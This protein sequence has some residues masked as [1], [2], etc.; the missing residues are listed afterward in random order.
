MQP[1]RARTCAASA[2]NDVL[3]A[4]G[5]HPGDG[6]VGCLRQFEKLGCACG[7]DSSWLANAAPSRGT[8]PGVPARGSQHLA[9]GTCLLSERRS[10]LATS[11]EFIRRSGRE[12]STEQS[13]LVLVALAM[14]S[15]GELAVTV[16]CNLFR[17]KTHVN[18]ISRLLEP[19][20]NAIEHGRAERVDTT[21]ERLEGKL[22]FAVTEHNG[23]GMT[24]LD[25]EEAIRF[26]H[27]AAKA[28]AKVLHNYAH[29]G[30]GTK[31]CLNFFSKLA[32]FSVVQDERAGGG[33]TYVLL[34]LD[35]ADKNGDGQCQPAKRLVWTVKS[36]TKKPAWTVA[37]CGCTDQPGFVDNVCEQLVYLTPS[38][39]NLNGVASEFAK[40]GRTGTRMVYFDNEG[41]EGTSEASKQFIL[42][43][44]DVRVHPVSR[45]ITAPSDFRF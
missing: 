36:K 34:L 14:A 25:C 22:T 27:H 9:R 11:L 30:I 3:A 8:G 28:D 43:G 42:D 20:A 39:R 4:A 37:G 29:N 45:S 7:K 19:I 33:K 41:R 26:G 38:D 21:V 13:R 10:K 32:I 35:V 23:A 15:G 18:P 2:D 31:A 17:G 5:D 44:Q 24:A 1:A 12:R 16:D 6:H 40:I